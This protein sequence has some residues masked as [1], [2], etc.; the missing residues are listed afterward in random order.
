MKT[1]RLERK[2]GFEPLKID[3]GDFT[4]EA[5][6]YLFEGIIMHYDVLNRNKDIH[7][8]LYS[9]LC[10]VFDEYSKYMDSEH[11]DNDFFYIDSLDGRV[12]MEVKGKYEEI[13]EEDDD[14]YLEED[15]DE[16]F[17]NRYLIINLFQI[18]PIIEDE[19]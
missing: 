15:D 12:G 5:I 1:L 11:M 18:N 4:K 8:S 10:D 14:E 2:N 17:V 3:S 6:P 16:Y 9:F 13:F 19:K 7:S